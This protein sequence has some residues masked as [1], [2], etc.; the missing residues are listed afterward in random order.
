MKENADANTKKLSKNNLLP[1]ARIRGDGGCGNKLYRLVTTR[2]RWLHL[3]LA[4]AHC[5]T[6]NFSVETS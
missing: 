3:P 2:H 6:K 4:L 1:P 5:T